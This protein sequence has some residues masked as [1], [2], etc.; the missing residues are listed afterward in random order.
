[1]LRCTRN[2]IHTNLFASFILRAVSILTRDA[3][4]MKDAPEFR[5]NKDVS[6]V[7]SDQ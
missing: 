2:Y 4:L 1:K 3:L 6:I 5:D 7:L